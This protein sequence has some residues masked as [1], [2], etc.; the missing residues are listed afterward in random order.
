M[1]AIQG[2]SLFL[3]LLKRILPKKCVNMET[4]AMKKI[5][6]TSLLPIMVFL[7]A[8]VLASCSPKVGC[9]VNEEVHSAV[10]RK[11]ELKNKKGK[12]SLFSPKMSRDMKK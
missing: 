10:N 6:K 4:V 3:S 9:P 1:L 5:L 8:F 7:S 12:S 11:G 2:F